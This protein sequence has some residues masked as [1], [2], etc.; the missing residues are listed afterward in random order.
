M[1]LS[2]RDGALAVLSIAFAGDTASQ[3]A[4]AAFERVRDQYVPAAFDGTGAHRGRIKLEDARNRDWEDIASFTLD[5]EPW[6]LVDRLQ[7]IKTWFQHWLIE[8]ELTHQEAKKRFGE[9]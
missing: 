2:R 1:P 8:E 6:L 5:G 9:K 4:L 3:L 7:R